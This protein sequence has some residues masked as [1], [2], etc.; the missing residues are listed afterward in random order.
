[1]N[2]G[3][4]VANWKRH[5]KFWLSWTPVWFLF[6]LVGWEVGGRLG[7]PA[8][9]DMI[10]EVRQRREKAVKDLSST[11]ARIREIV[12][13]AE[14]ERVPP[15]VS[16]NA[17]VEGKILQILEDIRYASEDAALEE[18][19]YSVGTT[20]EECVTALAREKGWGKVERISVLDGGDSGYAWGFRF[21]AGGTGFK[22][23]GR[24]VPGGF[25]CT[26]WK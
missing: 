12:E 23:A 3:E 21:V 13:H 6:C 16:R 20:P 1:M 7:R 11:A 18:R 26:W 5:W 24:K 10:E 14:A 9:G 17:F 22:A 2:L 4:A 15:D 19:I 25:A 8:G